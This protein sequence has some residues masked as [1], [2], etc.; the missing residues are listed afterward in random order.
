MSH[1]LG[2]RFV[3]V[4][5]SKHEGRGTLQ[6]KL[7]HPGQPVGEEEGSEDAAMV[8]MAHFYLKRRAGA[9]VYSLLRNVNLLALRCAALPLVFVVFSPLLYPLFPCRLQ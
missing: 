1:L 5:L 9:I 8:A 4:F 2:T 3:F 7:H 6:G